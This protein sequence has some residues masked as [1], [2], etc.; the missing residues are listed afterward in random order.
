M[1]ASKFP[2]SLKFNI[3]S[4]HAHCVFLFYRLSEGKNKFTYT[5]DLQQLAVY[6]KSQNHS[7]CK[8]WFQGNMENKWGKKIDFYDTLQK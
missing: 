2:I 7:N 1:S 3:F 8:A 6:V 4:M 5:E